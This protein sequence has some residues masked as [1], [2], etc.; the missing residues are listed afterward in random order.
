MVTKYALLGRCLALASLASCQN[1]SSGIY[2]SFNIAEPGVIKYRHYKINPLAL[3]EEWLPGYSALLTNCSDNKYFCMYSS[4]GSLAVANFAVPMRC[5]KPKVGDIWRAH[6]VTTKVVGVR[7]DWPVKKLKRYFLMSDAI[8]KLVFEYT[9]REGIV[10]IHQADAVDI[11]ASARQGTLAG[12]KVS[13][14]FGERI[15]GQ[16]LAAYVD[17]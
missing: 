7:K 2:T 4:G 9:P 8:P 6:V 3:N 12:V 1:S 11:A 10:A 14:V 5:V 13:P 16:T 15:G 17:R